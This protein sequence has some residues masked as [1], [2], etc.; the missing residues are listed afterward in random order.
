MR[1]FKLLNYIFCL[2]FLGQLISCKKSDDLLTNHFNKSEINTIEKIIQYFDDYV[3]SQ[4]GNQL[5]IDK[6]YTA[7]LEKIKSSVEKSSD[8]DLFLPAIDDRID[9]YET[10]DKNILSEI[11][12]IRDTLTI[13]F[14]GENEPRKCYS[15]YSFNLNLQG[16]YFDFLKD[17]S[18]KNDFFKSY[19]ETIQ[20]A[21]DIS[22]T[23]YSKI[24]NEHS[25]I[26]FDNREERLI[27]IISLLEFGK[28][29]YRGQIN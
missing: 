8:L 3:I 7:Y 26:D 14:R 19:Y 10:L 12:D 23:S 21:G 20:V 25:E 24:L 18:Y 15:P 16:K 4:T 22:P 27:V 11:Y 13:H 28:P 2:I 17:L 1:R 29:I 6:A 9:F 5:T